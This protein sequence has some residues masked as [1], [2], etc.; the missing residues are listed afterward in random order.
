MN[1]A[2]KLAQDD[3]FRK[4]PCDML[5]KLLFQ[6]A[7]Q[8]EREAEDEFGFHGFLAIEIK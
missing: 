5:I 1:G 8:N 2:T 6:R 4:L 3:H 7:A